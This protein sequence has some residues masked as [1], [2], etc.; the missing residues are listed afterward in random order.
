M[1]CSLPWRRS[2]HNPEL[3][4]AGIVV[5]QFQSRARQPAAL[6]AELESEGLP[7]LKFYLRATVK[8]WESHQASL[9]MVH[10]DPSHPLTS[11]LLDLSG[12]INKTRKARKGKRSKG[13]R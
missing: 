10:L 5:N 4:I 11:E 8:V 9:P 3:E 12:A 2:I 6:V 1:T 7:V 13:A